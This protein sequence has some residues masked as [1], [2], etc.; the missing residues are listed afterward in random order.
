MNESDIKSIEKI[1]AAYT[2]RPL[3]NLERLKK[4]D[5][6]V[7]RP[8]LILAYTVG[9]VGALV[10]GCGMCLAMPEVI[11]GYMALGIVVGLIGIAI[12]ALNYP[13]YKAILRGRRCRAS[14][15]ILRLSGEML[16]N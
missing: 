8:A 5:R 6:Q 13:L 9:T 3:T 12:G 14:E 16:G 4:M 15:E 2:E 7:T 10:L 1:R 11:E